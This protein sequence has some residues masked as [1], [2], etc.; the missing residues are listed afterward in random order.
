MDNKSNDVYDQYNNKYISTYLFGKFTKIFKPDVK[1][2]TIVTE[3]DDLKTNL[4]KGNPVFIIGYGASGAGKTSSLIY[5]NKTKEDGVIIEL[6]N[7][8]GEQ[9]NTLKIMINEFYISKNNDTSINK[10]NNSQ[11]I[12]NNDKDNFLEFT[13]NKKYTLA[14]QYTYE[15]HHKYRLTSYTN[16]N[17]TNINVNKNNVT[18]NKGCPLGELMTF[19]IDTDRLVKATT[20]NP[21]SSRSHSL[22]TIELSNAENAKNDKNAKNKYW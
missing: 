15:P 14:K 8:Y 20:N 3:L 12:F 19:L 5:L 1:N 11:F 2:S 17:N 4:D 16:T 6:C 13:Y 22:I 9:H 7:Y 18:F 10:T 21:N